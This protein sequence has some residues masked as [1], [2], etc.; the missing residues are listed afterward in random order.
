MYGKGRNNIR[1]SKKSYN[2]NKTKCVNKYVN[3]V[4]NICCDCSISESE[5]DKVA[6]A[7]EGR[8]VEHQGHNEV[9][10]SKVVECAHYDAKNDC[11]IAINFENISR[12][13]SG[14]SY[15][16]GNEC[17]IATQIILENKGEGQSMGPVAE[18]RFENK[19]YSLGNCEQQD[20]KS[21]NLIL[22]QNVNG[23]KSL[24]ERDVSQFEIGDLI[25]IGIWKILVW[26]RMI[27]I[28]GDFMGSCPKGW[29]PNNA[30][31][32]Q[33]LALYPYNITR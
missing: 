25:G 17:D 19:V 31:M 18:N 13:N 15:L 26:I 28:Q 2:K 24:I 22:S 29:I 10:Q 21:N 3:K 5:A 33:D 11:E 8:S 7:S 6:S 20:W 32:C 27:P 30:L 14:F 23:E 12:I 9:I 1:K 16:M 4:V